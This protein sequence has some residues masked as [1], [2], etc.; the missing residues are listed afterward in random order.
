VSFV[1]SVTLAN[2]TVTE[3]QVECCCGRVDLIGSIRHSLRRTVTRSM[4][5]RRDLSL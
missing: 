3:R 5:K 1:G 4:I 2:A